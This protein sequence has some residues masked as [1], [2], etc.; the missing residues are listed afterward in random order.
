MNNS[1]EARKSYRL[2]QISRL[3]LRKRIT[4]FCLLGIFLAVENAHAVD[5]MRIAT[6]G[7]SPSIPPYVTSL[8]L[9]NQAAFEVVA[10]SVAS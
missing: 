10:A 7:Y 5:K 1:R 4:I 6:G 9:P 3:S 8:S 2:L